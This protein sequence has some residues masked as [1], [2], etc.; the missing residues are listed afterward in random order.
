MV[1]ANT[2]FDGDKKYRSNAGDFDG[3]ANTAVQCGAHCQVERMLVALKHYSID[4]RL[5]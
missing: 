3:Q 1:V 5:F 2:D 4:K